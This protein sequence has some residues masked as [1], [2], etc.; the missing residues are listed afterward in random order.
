MR[1]TSS[2]AAAV[3]ISIVAITSAV[4]AAGPATGR[5]GAAPRGKDRTTA[6][7]LSPPL[8]AT[9]YRQ[10]LYSSCIGGGAMLNPTSICPLSKKYRSVAPKKL[11]F[12]IERKQRKHTRM[13]AV[14]L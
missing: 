2:P 7:L 11:N 6:S 10:G 5:E 8:A 12:E 14:G 3:A 9:H 13:Q 4:A 1:V